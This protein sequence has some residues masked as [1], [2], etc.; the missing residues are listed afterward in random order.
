MLFQ[1]IMK[2]FKKNWFHLFIWAAMFVNLIFAPNL[3]AVVSTRGKPLHTQASIPA[4][5]D[6]ISFVVE[7]VEASFRDGQNLWKL[8]GWAFILPPKDIAADSFVREIIL[9][10]D[11][12]TY[13]FSVDPVARIPGPQS[14]F[15]DLGVSTNTLGFSALI[16]NQSIKAGKYR[17]GIIFRNDAD[18]VAYYSDKPA[19]YL[20]KSP[21]TIRLEKK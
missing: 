17:L 18:G 3:V 1:M 19:Y 15:N 4:E 10:S 2:F 21:N 7:G 13:A 6:Q 5:S 9:I 11:E 8:Y 14:Y 16:L 12:R 20:V